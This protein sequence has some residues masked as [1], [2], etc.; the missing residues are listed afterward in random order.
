[1]LYSLNG[2]FPNTIPF[3]IKLSNGKTRTDPSTFTEEE[4]ADAGYILVD[5]PPQITQNQLCSWD[6]QTLSWLVRDKTEEELRQEYIATVPRVVT[7]RQARLALLQQGL[8]ESVNSALTVMEGP[9]GEAARIE[10]EY[11][12]EVYRDSQL[13]DSLAQGF[14]WTEDTVL[15]LFVLANTL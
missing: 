6:S 1:M 8:L 7:M 11:A 3:R 14:G 13:V 2:K 10:W 5:N 12:N 15:E 9:E 4:I